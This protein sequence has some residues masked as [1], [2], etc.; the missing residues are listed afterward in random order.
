MAKTEQEFTNE[1]IQDHA[2]KKLALCVSLEISPLFTAFAQVL[3]EDS[4]YKEQVY[5]LLTDNCGIKGGLQRWLD[6][7]KFRVISNFTQVIFAAAKGEALTPT[8]DMYLSSYDHG[9]KH[10]FR[11]NGFGGLNFSD[12]VIRAQVTGMPKLTFQKTFLDYVRMD[13]HFSHK[14]GITPEY[15]VQRMIMA[16]LKKF[17]KLS[18]DDFLYEDQDLSIRI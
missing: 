14:N 12:I 8:I 13:V 16:A 15:P 7:D 2:T 9:D 1:L 3:N 18:S 6:G 4:S 11:A 10:D 5:H 17:I